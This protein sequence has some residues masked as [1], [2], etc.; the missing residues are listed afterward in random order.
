MFDQVGPTTTLFI[1]VFVG[2]ILTS[3]V[4]TLVLRGQGY[5][6][7]AILIVGLLPL[8]TIFPLEAIFQTSNGLMLLGLT[9]LAG[10]VFA[11]LPEF[12]EN[13]DVRHALHSLLV[14]IYMDTTMA[15]MIVRTIVVLQSGNVVSIILTVLVTTFFSA[16]AIPS[17]FRG[18][19]YMEKKGMKTD[20]IVVTIV[21]YA[22]IGAA[23]FLSPL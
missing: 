2:M 12:E 1:M 11:I 18:Y 4:A 20:L 17:T 13:H 23:M 22:I 21:V 19:S 16:V 7:T 15:L 10:C 14:C 9:F 5:F 6:K 3:M 8:V